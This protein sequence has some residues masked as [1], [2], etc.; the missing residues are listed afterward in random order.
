MPLVPGLFIGR[1]QRLH[2]IP[3]GAAYPQHGL[4]VIPPRHHAL[5]SIQ[6]PCYLVQVPPDGCEL[7]H[8]AV[9]RMPVFL[10]KRRDPPQVGSHQRGNICGRRHAP[11]RRPLL[12]EQ[13]IAGVQPH[14]QSD[15]AIGSRLLVE[16]SDFAGR[17]RAQHDLE[18]LPDHRRF[19][20]LLALREDS[21]EG[22]H[23]RRDA[24]SDEGR[25]G[26][27]GRVLNNSRRQAILHNRRL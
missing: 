15:V 10:Q 7:G 12:Q 13:P 20:F 19:R 22:F 27:R 5:T 18:K 4:H 16:Q 24:S 11:G 2:V 25:R 8:H 23:L 1:E 21:Q 14:V 6:S 3:E 9:E 26:H 17:R